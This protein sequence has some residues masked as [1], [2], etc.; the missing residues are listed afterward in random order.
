[1]VVLAAA[2]GLHAQ[3]CFAAG[4]PCLVPLSWL[5]GPMQKAFGAQPFF[6]AQSEPSLL[7]TLSWLG[8]DRV[9]P[10]A[11]GLSGRPGAERGCV[12]R[13]LA[14]LVGH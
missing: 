1:M 13:V 5:P 9:W 4:L 2:L 14:A 12:S 10:V 11:S 6:L 7:G 8:D 3:R